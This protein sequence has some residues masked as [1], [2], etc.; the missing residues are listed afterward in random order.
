MKY[1]KTEKEKKDLKELGQLLEKKYT[2][3]FCIFTDEQ[4][5]IDW[6][7]NC[8]A[9]KDLYNMIACAMDIKEIR[10]ILQLSVKLDIMHNQKVGRREDLSAKEFE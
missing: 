3:H 2:T 8:K 10:E 5:H 9:R 7:V 1:K 4:G 6:L